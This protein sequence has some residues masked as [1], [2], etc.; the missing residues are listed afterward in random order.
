MAR[1]TGL[2]EKKKKKPKKK[3]KKER[4]RGGEKKVWQE[5][6][7]RQKGTRTV[8]VVTFGRRQ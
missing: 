4:R 3:K 8:V 5:I 2:L 6:G 7:L 1:A